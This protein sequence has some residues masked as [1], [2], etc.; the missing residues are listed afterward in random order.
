MKDILLQLFLLI[1]GGIVFIP[2]FIIGLLYTFFKHVYQLDY[3]PRRQLVPVIRS[4]T[5]ILDGLANAGAG[6]LLNDTFK[7]HTEIKYGKWYQTISAVTGL[8]YLKIKD[9]SL[10]RLLDKVL[11][12]NHCIDAISEEDLFYHLNNNYEKF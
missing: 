7:V 1:I 4:I 10:R 5:L 11:G 6:E 3:N 8:I 2:L 12:N 9:T